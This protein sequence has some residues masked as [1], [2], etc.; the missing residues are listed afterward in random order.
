VAGGQFF[1]ISE[2]RAGMS[3][4]PFCPNGEEDMDLK[5]FYQKVRDAEMRIEDDPTL[6][7]SLETSDGG[8][9]DVVSEVPRVVAARMFVEGIARA[10]TEP[11]IGEYRQRLEDARRRV[12]EE[13]SARRVQV[14]VISESDLRSI[15]AKDCS[16]E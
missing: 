6:V 3:P 1:I 13:A 8:K 15:R 11:E 10:A 16:K 5:I 9:P 12:E 2:G 4:F 14:T 7:V